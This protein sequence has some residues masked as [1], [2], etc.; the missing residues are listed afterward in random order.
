MR[1]RVALVFMTLNVAAT[2]ALGGAIAYDFAHHG[3]GSSAQPTAAGVAGQSYSAAPA[4]PSDSGGAA[5]V[6]AAPTASAAPSSSSSPSSA[7]VA[8][9]GATPVAA[10]SAPAA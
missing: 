8:S 6:S 3:S 9:S 1:E 2:L 7:P 5:P 10:Q 4:A